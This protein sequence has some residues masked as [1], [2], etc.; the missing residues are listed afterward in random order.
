MT[1][2]G[3]IEAMPSRMY[4]VT[5]RHE[6]G[7]WDKPVQAKSPAAARAE[8]WR[9]MSDAW[10]ISFRDFLRI[11]KVRRDEMDPRAG[12]AYIRR[13]YGKDFWRGQ[14][15]TITGEGAHLEGRG[16]TVLYPNKDSTAHVRL[17]IDGYGIGWVHPNSAILRALDARDD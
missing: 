7:T 13:T 10:D 14:R 15:V 17:D 5:V 11:S 12:Y 3:L 4:V 8:A 6:R 9:C 1:I 2:R 16:A